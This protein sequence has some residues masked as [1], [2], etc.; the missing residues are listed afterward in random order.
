LC[1]GRALRLGRLYSGYIKCMAPMSSL[2]SS[3]TGGNA[4]GKG[5]PKGRIEGK[6]RREVGYS[7]RANTT[8]GSRAEIL[9]WEKSNEEG[10]K[11]T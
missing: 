3:E 9:A 10:H 2:G 5:E 1:R 7:H 8:S 11:G 4:C 6:V